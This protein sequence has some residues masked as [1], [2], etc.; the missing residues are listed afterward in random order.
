VAVVP[1]DGAF[2]P[3]LAERV[4]DIVAMGRYAHDAPRVAHERV[5]VDA[6]Q[7]TD[8]WRL[9][10]RA[11]ASL[12]GGERRRVLLARALA[13]EPALILLDEPTTHLDLGHQ[14]DFIRLIEEI[15]CERSLTVLAV[16]HD[17][18]LAAAWCP[19]ALILAGGRV[20]A[21]GATAQVLT[22]ELIR[23]VYGLPAV[24]GPDG[25]PFDFFTS[26]RVRPHRG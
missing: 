8:L 6:L 21:V 7:R 3:S 22:A 5:V 24:S 19:R 14:A 10:R 25:G 13:Q 4:E 18:N 9:R 26:T 15:R 23:R 11:V 16:L 17:L 12:S 1:Q 20:Q 2:A